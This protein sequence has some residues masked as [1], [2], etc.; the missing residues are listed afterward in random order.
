M[1]EGGP[2]GSR[3]IRTLRHLRAGARRPLPVVTLA[4]R[5]ARKVPASSAP[6]RTSAELTRIAT[7]TPERT[8]SGP[9]S[10]RADILAVATALITRM[11]MVM[12]TC[13]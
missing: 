3:W 10:P 7:E 9:V 6:A 4:R 5:G 11:P 13:W 8:P 2:D 12:P 1:P